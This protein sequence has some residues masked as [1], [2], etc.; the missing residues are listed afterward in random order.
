[1]IST[2]PNGSAIADKLPDCST[3]R[4]DIPQSSADFR[5]TGDI[6]TTLADTLR[7]ISSDSRRRYLKSFKLIEEW[8][9]KPADQIFLRD[10]FV[11]LTMAGFRPFLRE[12]GYIENT[13]VAYR[14]GLTY[15]RNLAASRGVLVEPEYKQ[16]WLEVMKRA[17]TNYCMLF[18]EH[19]EAL[20]DSPDDLPVEEVDLLV[21]DL[22]QK[23]Q[24]TLG[25]GRK[26]RSIF[27]RTLREC[28]FTKRQPVA[29]ASE[30]NYGVPLKDLP[31]PL[32]S[33]VETLKSWSTQSD[34]DG[35]WHMDWDHYEEER[36][37][38]YI[39]LREVTASKVVGEICRLYGFVKNVCDKAEGIVSLE[40]LL[41]EKIV[42]S[43][44]SWWQFVKKLD[45]NGMRTRLGTLFSTLKQ[46][47]QASHINLTWV[48]ALL[49]SIPVTSQTAVQVRKSTRV[50][51][52]KELEAIPDLLRKERN[53]M[54]FQ[55]NRAEKS[56]TSRRNH[57]NG[58]TTDIK[59]C[60][61][62]TTRLLRIAAQAQQELIIRFLVTLVWRNENLS[63]CRI[64]P[65][66]DR[67]ANLVKSPVVR[68]PGKDIPEWAEKLM[69]SDPAVRLFQFEFS[70]EETKAAR[71]V[72]GV[73]PKNLIPYVEEF[74][75]LYRPILVGGDDPETMDDPGTLFVNRFGN[76][77]SKQQL[78][79]AV[80]E[81]TI[82]YVGK[83]VNPHLFRDIYA[84]EYLLDPENHADY[85][86]LSKILWHGTPEITVKK[87]AWMFNES[88]GTSAAGEWAEKRERASRSTNVP[89]R[90]GIARQR[91]A[92][93]PIPPPAPF[94]KQR[95]TS[96]GLR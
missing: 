58:S 48:P 52:M 59:L 61:V 70:E 15:L 73:L 39:E 96:R 80:E 42:R 32:R 86:T 9:G 38:Q 77:I 53:K 50:V 21:F 75:D 24:A 6:P 72:M 87:Y 25:S 54:T 12:K 37:T 83:S 41:Q 71:S 79:E 95:G 8:Q 1:M 49:Q 67:P 91:A 26:A 63:E 16:D 7:L 19:F 74:L 40:T 11:R 18:A 33:Q 3:N 5:P 62:R 78:E 17:K 22:V 84:L 81:A 56:E 43:F 76:A 93:I 30:E 29:A 55:H 69:R 10:L 94:L 4:Q 44:Q 36:K 14:K 66:G 92:R 34:D 90:T 82:R 57:G 46:Y 60:K 47:P 45:G 2:L 68:K 27:L 13:I 89:A 88:I 64:L 20:Y 65:N 85:F 51:S 28:G 31:E 23:G 35:E